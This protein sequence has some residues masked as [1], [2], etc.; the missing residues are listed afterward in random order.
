MAYQ[1]KA[2]LVFSPRRVA[3][4]ISKTPKTTA[5]SL[6]GISTILLAEADG[7]LRGSIGNL[8]REHGYH[9]LE[10]DDQRSTLFI[11]QT[12]S[13]QID[14]LVI[15]IDLDHSHFSELLQKHRPGMLRTLI[16]RQ[17]LWGASVPGAVLKNVRVLLQTPEACRE[18]DE[19]D[20]PSNRNK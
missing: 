18:R 9:V 16:P 13:R 10:A 17:G 4:G 20:A 2:L 1:T 19:S 8:L 6:D 12:H 5:D 3:M 15:A 7:E 11:A 14:L